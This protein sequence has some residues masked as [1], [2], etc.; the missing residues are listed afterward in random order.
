MKGDDFIV[1]IF[2]ISETDDLTIE[3]FRKIA[4]ENDDE[5]KLDLSRER[6]RE[7]VIENEVEIK[8]IKRIIFW[9]IGNN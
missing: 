3:M 8:I 9:I 7:I 6:E 2:E 4:I 5:G 1:E